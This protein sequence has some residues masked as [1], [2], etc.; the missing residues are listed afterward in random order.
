MI[1]KMN[2]LEDGPIIKLLYQLPK[3]GWRRT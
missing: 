2:A 1:L 3:P